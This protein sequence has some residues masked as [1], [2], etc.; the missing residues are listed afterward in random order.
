MTLEYVPV[1]RPKL[2][3]ADAV[4]PYLRRLDATRTYSNLGPLVLEFEHRIAERLRLTP[5]AVV[6]A[7]NGTTALIA[8]IVATAGRATAAKPYALIPSYTF[9]ATAAAVE[10]CGYIPYLADVDET[11]WSLEPERI[12]RE[13]DLARVGVV[14]PVSPYGRPA[15]QAPWVDFQRITGIP[16]VIDGAASFD[17]T[18]REPAS[19]FGEIPVALSFHA[20][21]CFSTGEGGG[22][23]TTTVDLAVAARRALNFGFLMSRESRSAS[24]NGRMSEYHAAVGLAEDDGWARKRADLEAV[25]AAYREVA[26]AHGIAERLIASPEVS[27]T[28]VL[29]D[30]RDARECEALEEAFANAKIGTRLWYSFGIAKQPY[31]ANSPGESLARTDRLS[32]RVL[33]L[34]VAPDLSREAI[35][36]VVRTIVATVGVASVR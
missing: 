19:A 31:Y 24:T 32:A 29:F 5:A 20:T 4:L 7:S 2:P 23:V 13:I 25:T 10:Q 30:C 18:E 17:T 11:D 1:L 22:V 28:Y 14:V 15:R 9:V 34:P 36:R 3:D 21:K 8:A 27:L 12:I 35:E 26:R 6:S 33:G 16:V